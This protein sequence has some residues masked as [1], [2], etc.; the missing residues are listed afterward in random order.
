MIEDLKRNVEQEQKI[1][2]DLNTLES[3]VRKYSG[4]I[5]SYSSSKI[6]LLKQ[7][8]IVNN[9][10][11][12]LLKGVLI[13]GNSDD[14]ARS[15]DKENINSG[16]S[17]DISR[18]SYVSPSSS[19]KRFVTL[20]NDS[21]K[22]YIKELQIS[23]KG[24]SDLKQSRESQDGVMVRSPSALAAISNKLFSGLSD[25]ISPG[26]L[27][28]SDD[29]KK[30][31]L[32]FMLSTYLSI[33]LFVSVS[34]LI[35]SA[36]IFAALNYLGFI[37]INFVWIP[38]ALVAISLMIFY[39]Y[40]SSERRYV[41]KKISQELPF[42]AIHMAAIAGSDIEPTKIFKIIAVSR[43]YKYIGIEIRKVVNQ[44]EIYGYDL[45]SALN[46]VAK[47]TS[48]QKLAKLLTGLAINISSGGE[49]K[50]YLEK[51]AESY[52]MDYKLERQRYSALAGT[53]MD[54]YISILITAPLIFMM[55]FIL[56]NVSGLSVGYGID[57]LMVVG[58][59]LV[60][61]ANIIFL[62][63]LQFKQPDV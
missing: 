51:N 45:V 25:K 57:F 26:F 18:F 23:E 61:I 39:F 63:I 52:M 19:E 11:P 5:K 49:L 36:S 28:L 47:Q 15:V 27:D 1:L 59:S 56:M 40:P 20:D 30:A 10:V 24:F 2:S 29:L 22:D 9:S 34:V 33:A 6:S 3:H 50:S 8:K 32:R 58:I 16:N 21:R 13:S 38:F 46:N 48:N 12:K 31:N 44:I 42:A 41:Q 17:R 60:V 14:P 7:L 54:V 4:N 62:F 37:A 35:V 53:F 55:L 43:E